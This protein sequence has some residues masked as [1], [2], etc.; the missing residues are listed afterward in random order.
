MPRIGGRFACAVMALLVAF[1]GAASAQSWPSRPITALIP[2]APGNA[3]DLAA[4]IVMDQVGKQLGATIVIEN[5]GGAGGTIA[6]NQTARAAPDGYTVVVHSSSFAAAYVTHKSLPYNTLTD[7]TAIAPIGTQP[8]VLV[9][10]P[11]KNIKTAQELIA[12]AKAKPG[13]MNFASAGRGAASHLA[14]ERFRLAAG[15]EAQHIPFK[16]PVEAL[17]EVMAGRID[18]Y[19]L[20]ISPALPLI[21]QGKVVA[22]A[23]SSEKRAKQ[24]PD[25][26]TTREIGLKDAAYVFWNGIF[27][28]AK[29]PADIVS[30]LHAETMKALDVPAVVERLGKLGVEPL[31]LSPADFDKFFKADVLDT[32]KLAKAAGIEKQ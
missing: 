6:V 12:G 25:V 20:P 23:V 29:M 4:R 11:S 19:F 22:L 16:G 15:I 31:K 8:T 17:S 27:G 13:A 7:F 30:R 14:A 21:Q 9:V 26:P 24:L 18:F 10:A 28:P 32:E 1:G 3:N 2:F 5:R